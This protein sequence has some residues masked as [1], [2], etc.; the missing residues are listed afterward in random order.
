M[1]SGN[2]DRYL[3]MSGAR[4]EAA[5]VAAAGADRAAAERLTAEATRAAARKQVEAISAR[6][7]VRTAE[8]S[9]GWRRS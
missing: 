1:E 3:E 4:R 9:A 2:D 8:R 7:R 6:G 5:R